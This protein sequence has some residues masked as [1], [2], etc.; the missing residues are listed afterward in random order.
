MVPTPRTSLRADRL[1]ALNAPQ[2][3]TVEL[4]ASGSPATVK[5]SDSRTV[6]RSDGML[7]VE[8]VNETWRLDDEWWRVPIHRRYFEVVLEDGRRAVLFEDLN[9]GDWFI[10]RP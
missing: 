6:G 8:F 3:A 1:R 2:P 10:Q 7:K 4:D 5:V 9:T